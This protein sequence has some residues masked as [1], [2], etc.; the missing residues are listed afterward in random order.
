MLPALRPA[1]KV[2]MASSRTAVVWPP[3]AKCKK[4]ADRSRRQEL[5]GLLRVPSMSAGQVGDYGRRVEKD[6][7]ALHQLRPR[8]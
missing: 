6:L 8:E 2:S 1:P 3:L 4:G 7:R 5:P